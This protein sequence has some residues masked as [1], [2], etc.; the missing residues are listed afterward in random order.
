MG[1]TIFELAIQVKGPFVTASGAEARFGFDK[2]TAR[3][4]DGNAYIPGTLLL[5]RARHALKELSQLTNTDF[6]ATIELLGGSANIGLEP[7][8]KQLVIHD[9]KL[10]QPP[11]AANRT[12][13]RIAIDASTGTAEDRA[14]VV[15]DSALPVGETGEFKG[16]V[17]VSGMSQKAAKPH[18][19][20][21]SK[22]LLFCGRLGADTS[23]GFGE[24]V[25]I[26]FKNL[27][28]ETQ[29][30]TEASALK[31]DSCL[32][33]LHWE[34]PF[35][36]NDQTQQANLFKGSA[37]VPGGAI[38]GALAQ[39]WRHLMKIQGV[40]TGNYIEKGTDPGRPKLS[41]HFSRLRIEMAQAENMQKQRR[42]PIPLSWGWFQNRL[43]DFAQHPVP[44]SDLEEAPAF[45]PDW[46]YDVTQAANHLLQQDNEPYEQRLHIRTAIDAANGRAAESQL[47]AYEEVIASNDINWLCLV[48]F[49]SIPVE[50]RAAAKAEFISLLQELGQLT[51][52]GKTKARAT[53]GL[54]PAPILTPLQLNA[55]DQ[56]ILTFLSP[57]LIGDIRQI[58]QSASS[59]QAAYE[60]DLAELSGASLTLKHHFSQQTLQGGD[61][62]S[63]RTGQKS[64]IP[65]LLTSPGSVWVLEVKQAEQAQA[66][67]NSWQTEGIPTPEW[68]R[69]LYS[70]GADDTEIWRTNP[71]IRANGFGSIA[72]NHP[73]CHPQDM[74]Y[75][76]IN[77][78]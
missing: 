62:L 35:C 28:K 41:E 40:T 27:P 21:L 47:F 46:K 76:N 54:R 71:Y 2:L 56:V 65:W 34:N 60:S 6:S 9:L 3:M 8:R 39:N 58:D 45:Q 4:P 26:S 13:H 37:T 78:A 19:L 42:L 51:H 77:R 43:V 67:L 73:A 36:F 14:L 57:T 61:Y 16:E 17:T 7:Q 15:I 11:S 44:P 68:A 12:L 29:Q 63:R 74:Q 5:G 18:L 72:V 50:D 1:A 20:L 25:D 52:L 32:L 38:K 30:T 10:T 66:V 75:L 48:H 69:T 55:G 33:T 49:Q 70:D 31:G 24:I 22:A 64:Y 23:V 59:L 53:L